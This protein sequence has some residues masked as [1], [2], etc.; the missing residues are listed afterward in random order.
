VPPARLAVRASPAL[1]RPVCPRGLAPRRGL[2]SPEIMWCP[3]HDSLCGLRPPCFVQFVRG[4][5]RLAVGWTHRKLWGAP[6]TTRCAG[7]ARLASSSL[8]GG[9]CASPW[10]GLTGNYGVPPARL[11]VRASPAL[12]RPVCPGGLAPRRGLDSPEIMWCPRHD[13]LCGLRPPCFVQF[14]RGGLRLAVGWTH[15]KLCGA[16]GTTRTCDSRFRKPVLYPPELRGRAARSSI[17]DE[18]AGP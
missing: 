10:A 3:R 1:L 18:G 7:F 6:G 8:S 13:S 17:A 12:L 14:V 16:P 15:R 2:D 5:L 11:A 9:A 4:G